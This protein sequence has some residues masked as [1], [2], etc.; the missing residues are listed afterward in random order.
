MQCDQPPPAAVTVP[1]TMKN[2]SPRVKTPL[3]FLNCISQ[4]FCHSCEGSKTTV[5]RLLFSLKREKVLT[6]AMNGNTMQREISQSPQTSN[7]ATHLYEVWVRLTENR[8]AELREG[9]EFVLAGDQ[10]HH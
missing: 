3:P 1:L 2:G 7:R 10:T 5:I 8:T 9:K 4:V 6:Y